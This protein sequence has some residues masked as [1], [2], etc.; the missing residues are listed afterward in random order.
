MAG[1]QRLSLFHG[2]RRSEYTSYSCYGIITD[3]HCATTP[4]NLALLDYH[5]WTD[6]LDYCTTYMLSELWGLVEPTSHGA[7]TGAGTGAGG[8]GAASRCKRFLGKLAAGGRQLRRRM[9]LKRSFFSFPQQDLI[10]FW[11]GR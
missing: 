11:A 10:R 1:L 3:M 4:C 2:T 7:G 9:A 6:D 8:G 5:T